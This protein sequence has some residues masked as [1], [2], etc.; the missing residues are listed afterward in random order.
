MN[1][2]SPASHRDARN[3]KNVMDRPIKKLPT[4]IMTGACSS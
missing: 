2:V 3:E 1:G 4:E